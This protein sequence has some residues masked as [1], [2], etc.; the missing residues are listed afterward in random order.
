MQLTSRASRA[1]RASHPAA[2]AALWL[3][4]STIA[5]GCGDNLAGLSG[6]GAG[7][8]AAGLPDGAPP[9]PDGAPPA[10]DAGATVPDA[11]PP[12]TEGAQSGGSPTA[13]ELVGDLA[14]VG[15]GP[16]LAIWRAPVGGGAPALVGQ[17][18]P[19]PGVVT[20]LVVSGT[21]VFVAERVDLAGRIHVID[22][23]DP[24]APVETSSFALASEGS[25]TTPYG[26]AVL[27]DRLFVA[28]SQLGIVELDVADPDA[29]L[30][31]ELTTQL[32]IDVEVVGER[33]YYVGQS[34]IGGGVVGALDLTDE[35]APLG[36]TLLSLA[37]GFV[38]TPS[39]LVVA[40][41]IDGIHVVDMTDP[42]QPVERFA[43]ADPA[44]GPFAR[45]LA[46]SA[47]A[48]WIPAEDGMYVLDL[49]TPTAITL[50]GPFLL[51]TRGANA[52][53]SA[54]GR[55]AEVTDRGELRVFDVAGA[56]PSALPSAA[57]TLCADCVGL[58][59][60]GERLVAADFAGGLR[61]G[62]ADD[63]SLIGRSVEPTEQVVFEDVALAGDTAYAADWAFGLRIYD[64]TDPA[65]PALTGQVDT[66][67]YPSSVAVVGTRAYLGESTNGGNLRVIDVADPATAAEIGSIATSQARGL[68]VRGDLAY[69][70]DGSLG[71]PG[72]LR[73]FDVSDPASISLVG[74]QGDGCGE[75]LDVALSGT[76]AVVACSFDGFQIVDVSDPASPAVLAVIPAGG[77]SSAWSVAAWDGGAAL[78]HDFGVIVVDLADPRAPVTV[79]EHAT[80]WTVSA[81]AAPGDGRLFAGCGLG[82]VYRWPLP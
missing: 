5:A 79:A 63:L 66:A 32:A 69:V 68:E 6:G 48:A 46:A 72:G 81:L 9:A 30:F 78:G 43:Y 13:I 41:G 54:D 2:L 64:V 61:T 57:V 31:V 42:A 36:E 52:A 1:P 29:P 44:G 14:Y 22:V 39:D 3:A 71:G 77:I 80:S 33:L 35:L 38:V 50:A 28:D 16:R 59:V 74:F 76:L 20:G 70:A 8:D 26:M 19:L 49:E 27:G 56:E 18:S 58:A 82:G 60:D 37:N 15:V 23:S 47:T 53:A 7:A 34:F 21:R 67:G 73:I 55:L 4:G 10:P 51:D 65:A 12:V 40:A 11:G 45:A 25:A 24:A 75:A 62:R 17:T